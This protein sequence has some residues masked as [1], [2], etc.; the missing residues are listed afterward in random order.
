MESEE[1]ARLNHLTKKSKLKVG[2]ELVVP[3]RPGS[4]S[5]VSMAPTGSGAAEASA[6]ASASKSAEPTAEKA[7]STSRA[8]TH[9]VASGETLSSVAGK[10]KLSVSELK[11]LNGLKSDKILVGQTLKV[12]TVSESASSSRKSA[13]DE[14]AAPA[15]PATP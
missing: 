4:S 5:L 1:I 3:A 12:G 11:S 10:Y 6:P 14:P 7:T 8:R 13:K 9:K 15:P 2:Q